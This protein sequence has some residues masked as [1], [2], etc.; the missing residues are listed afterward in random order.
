MQQLRPRQCLRE[1]SRQAHHSR[2]T[3]VPPVMREHRER[4]QSVLPQPCLPI[5]NVLTQGEVSHA[6]RAR[7]QLAMIL[8]PHALALPARA[9]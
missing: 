6:D 5:G 2:P 9:K 3:Y 7:A 4:L 1:R 8:Q